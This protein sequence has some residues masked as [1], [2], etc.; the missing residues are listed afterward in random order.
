MS[1]QVWWEKTVEY[2]FVC[3]FMVRYKKLFCAPLSGKAESSLG[4][5]LVGKDFK[6][7]LIEFKRS[8]DEVDSEKDKYFFF[9]DAK[10]S[11]MNCSGHHKIVFG[12]LENSR[13]GARVINY[14]H[15]DSLEDVKHI[16]RVFDSGVDHETFYDY[17]V[18]LLRF[19]KRDRRSG[20]GAFSPEEL[21]SVCGIAENG[22]TFSISLRE[23][24]KELVPEFSDE[25]T[26]VESE[27][28]SDHDS[29]SM[30]MNNNP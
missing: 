27:L 26:A 8:V 25:L 7:F 11:L 24:C 19:R 21:Q 3:W 28:D 2:Y 23:Y 14:F 20:S 9:E 13:F 4:D 6:F 15:L 18:K 10:T 16:N 1:E 30:E 29:S 22:D 5:L 12:A 17:V